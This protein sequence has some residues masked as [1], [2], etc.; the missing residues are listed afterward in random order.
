MSGPLQ[1]VLTLTDE[2]LDQITA[3]VSE[4]VVGLLAH[5]A[6]APADDWLTTKQAAAHLGMT[7]NA[8]HKLTSARTIRFTQDRPGS[9]CWFRRSDLDAWREGF[10]RGS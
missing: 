9:R 2:Q 8:L 4:R 7:P 10:G 5:Q 3:L 1:I 6:Q